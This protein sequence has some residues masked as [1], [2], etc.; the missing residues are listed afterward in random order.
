M[1]KKKSA[2]ESDPRRWYDDACGTAHALELLGERWALL[3]IRE[4]MFGPRRFSELKSSL[5][6][7]SAQALTQRLEGF[8]AAGV[9]VRRILPPPANV[10]VYELTEWG[11]ESEPILQ[12][13]GRWAARSPGH[14]PTLPLSAASMMQSL[15]TMISPER[16]KDIKAR[17]GFRFG[18]QEF[19]ADVR[20]GGIDIARGDASSADAVFECEPELMAA[21]TYGGHPVADA[22]KTDDL[23]LQGDRRLARRFLSLFD[24]P[25]KASCAS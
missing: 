23:S 13:M 19:I 12:V 10:Q 24:L 14:D 6:G 7:I 20:N 16:A 5:P 15:K 4:L 22:E 9:A 1:T 17:I 11:Y 2:P 21:I 3:I 18:R 8:E 25:P